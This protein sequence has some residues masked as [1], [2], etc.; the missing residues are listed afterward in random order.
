MSMG[1]LAHRVSS[2]ISR[3]V[4]GVYIKYS[5][6]GKDY[7]EQTQVDQELTSPL[8]PQEIVPLVSVFNITVLF[9]KYISR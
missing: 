3:S 8:K 5:G 4:S 6:E 2:T 9:V 7:I 1:T